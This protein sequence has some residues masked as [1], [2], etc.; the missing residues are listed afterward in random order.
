MQNLNLK[1]SNVSFSIGSDQILRNVNFNISNKEKICILGRNGSGKTSL[2]KL[3]SGELESDGGEIFKSSNLKISQF[4]QTLNYEKYETFEDILL[5]NNDQTINSRIYK[6]SK[7]FEINFKKKINEAS[8]G[9][10]R[11]CF[12]IKALSEE[13]NFLLLDE[14]TNHLDIR[15][16]EWLESFLLKCDKTVLIISH[17]RRFINNLCDRIF[18]I[19]EKELYDFKTNFYHFQKNKDFYLRKSLGDVNKLQKNLDKEIEWAKRGVSGR[20]KRNIR[21]LKNIDLL[22]DKLQSKN[23]RKTNLIMDFNQES[24][25]GSKVI[26]ANNVKIQI[27]KNVIIEEFSYIIRRG[28]KIAIIG[29]NGSGKTTLINTLLR[30]NNFFEGEI[31]LGTE[32][33]IA[34]FDQK[35]EITQQ[36]ITLKDYITE[37]YTVSSK[38][39]NDQLIIKGKAKHIIGYLKNFLFSESRINE[40][41]SILSGGEKARLMLAL[42]MSKDSNLLILDEPT[43]DLDEETSD[44]LRDLIKKYEGTVLFV[45]HDRDFIDEVATSSIYIKEKKLTFQKGGYKNFQNKKLFINNKLKEKDKVLKNNVKKKPSNKKGQNKSKYLLNEIEK[46]TLEINVIEKKLSDKN[47]FKEDRDV[48]D[49]NVKSL[50]FKKNQLVKLENEW[51][52]FEEKK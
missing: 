8:G 10:I 40:K 9:E 5:E 24:K 29:D 35:R 41:I 42:L 12:L 34:F 21:R 48:F 51:Y 25:S 7:N 38:I 4:Q 27:G 44:L 19:H 37:N 45:S 33:K 6:I 43:N 13:S 22:K 23:I 3:I 39:D 50:D 1:L 18:W 47:L 11:I 14:P 16:I 20:R 36:N 52:L 28:D 2:L 32:L 30:K 31:K 26:E 46:I 17:D 15:A 49:K